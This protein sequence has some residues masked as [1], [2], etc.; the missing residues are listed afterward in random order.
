MR[1]STKKK[2]WNG[3][4]IAVFLVLAFFFAKV[5][6]FVLFQGQGETGYTNILVNGNTITYSG[7][8]PKITCDKYYT[9]SDTHEFMNF[10]HDPTCSEVSGVQV[11][12]TYMESS[13]ILNFK[14]KINDMKCYVFG[15][16]TKYCQSCQSGCVNLQN[17]EYNFSGIVSWSNENGLV[18]TLD[19]KELN[20]F[21]DNLSQRNGLSGGNLIQAVFNGRVDFVY[22]PKIC[23]EGL[24]QCSGNSIQKC[25]GNEWITDQYCTY[26][27]LN[28]LCLDQNQEPQI[29][30][31][32]DYRC[33]SGN[34]EICTNNQW[35]L[36]Y[37][38]ET[39]CKDETVCNGGTKDYRKMW[40]VAGLSLAFILVVWFLVK[41]FSGG[42]RR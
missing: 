6:F 34:M 25:S 32:S 12:Q 28:G 26:G 17:G 38:C 29:C 1:K 18:C 16:M 8:Y 21:D 41:F 23:D 9:F 24:I 13:G 35:V 4:G 7:V 5:N 10:Q 2:I 36:K 11:C 42:K 20:N 33:N 15:T 30:T 27:C 3:I 40:I 14:D 22:S 19:M 39:G 37:K 31:E